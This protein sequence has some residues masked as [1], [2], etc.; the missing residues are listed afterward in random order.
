MSVQKKEKILWLPYGLEQEALHRYREP[1]GLEKKIQS[2]RGRRSRRAD[3]RTAT[4]EDRDDGEKLN[5]VE[6]KSL[7]RFLATPIALRECEPLEKT[8]YVSVR[9]AQAYP[10]GDIVDGVYDVPGPGLKELTQQVLASGKVELVCGDY[11]VKRLEVFNNLDIL[12]RAG[13]FMDVVIQALNLR[14]PKSD[15]KNLEPIYDFS[16]W[17]RDSDKRWPG[18]FDWG[19]VSPWIKQEFEHRELWI[20]QHPQPQS[21]TASTAADASSNKQDSKA[22]KPPV[23]KLPACFLDL[24]RELRFDPQL[25]KAVL[26]SVRSQW[27]RSRDTLTDYEVIDSLVIDV[28]YSAF[29]NGGKWVNACMNANPIPNWF[30]YAYLQAE[31]LAQRQLRQRSE[32]PRLPTLP[33]VPGRKMLIQLNPSPSIL[34]VEDAVLERFPGGR[35]PADD[36]P[37]EVKTAKKVDA[38]YE[39]KALFVRSRYYLPRQS[40][41]AQ[42]GTVP[43]VKQRNQAAMA[44]L[45]GTDKKVW[46][47]TNPAGNVTNRVRGSFAQEIRAEVAR[48]LDMPDDEWQPKHEWD[49]DVLAKLQVNGSQESVTVD[50]PDVNPEDRRSEAVAG[51]NPTEYEEELENRMEKAALTALER[52]V[53]RFELGLPEEPP[54][55]GD[56]QWYRLKASGKKKL[57]SLLKNEQ[58]QAS[59]SLDRRSAR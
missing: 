40:L 38:Y 30:G 55:V 49:E 42:L 19:R 45:R 37:N 3:S 28:A 59:Q 32:G 21:D 35:K 22:A 10:N 20:D 23:N 39:A 15:A 7:D 27:D 25:T 34:T 41:S 26:N 11:E 33:L 54:R 17:W 51:M 1:P 8:V 5:R 9:E 6:Q 24:F 31:G 16:R 56:T 13:E 52:Q 58:D 14:E 46:P 18:D 12:F 29:R 48:H 57:K 47:G 4:R 50:L 2:F 44:F 53:I 36:A 43:T